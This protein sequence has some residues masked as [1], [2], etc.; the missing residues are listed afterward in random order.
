MRPGRWPTFLSKLNK[1]ELM[2]KNLED[3]YRGEPSDFKTLFDAIK[4]FM[5]K[6]IGVEEKL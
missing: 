5:D 6:I 3:L 1:A 2:R 4:M